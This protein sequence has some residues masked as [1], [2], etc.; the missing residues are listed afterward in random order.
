M[1]EFGS[2]TSV[3]T[4]LRGGAAW[5]EGAPDRQVVSRSC[6]LSFSG[7]YLFSRNSMR[8][9]R[10]ESSFAR[11]RS[12]VCTFARVLRTASVQI[13]ILKLLGALP[14]SW[15]EKVYFRS[16]NTNISKS[17]VAAVW[18]VLGARKCP[19]QLRK[20]LLGLCFGSFFTFRVSNIFVL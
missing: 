7:F 8:P 14:L 10:P 13:L 6:R 12:L 17:A 2:Q 19:K 11:F 4:A 9:P 16:G 18:R 15:M 3:L 20:S 5:Q 1:R